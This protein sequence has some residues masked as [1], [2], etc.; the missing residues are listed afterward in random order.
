MRPEKRPDPKAR[1]K[2]DN[3]TKITVPMAM[4]FGCRLVSA[5]ESTTQR[6]GNKGE[7]LLCPYHHFQTIMSRPNLL[8]ISSNL[9]RRNIISAK[10]QNK[11][12]NNM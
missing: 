4:S 6:N 12:G 7:Q 2:R 8:S 9:S 1:R 10:A 5:K 11:D 3:E